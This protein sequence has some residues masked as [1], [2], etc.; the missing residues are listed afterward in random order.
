MTNNTNKNS[1]LVIGSTQQTNRRA[2]RLPAAL[3]ELTLR[4]RADE[5]EAIKVKPWTS[6]LC[7]LIP[8]ADSAPEHSPG[9]MTDS[10]PGEGHDGT[11]PCV[12]IFDCWMW[13][14]AKAN[15]KHERR[16]FRV[17][18]RFP[19]ACFLLPQPD[20]VHTI[21]AARAFSVVSCS[22]TNSGC[23]PVRPALIAI[24]WYEEM[25]R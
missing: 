5:P 1:F 7:S 23:F 4:T 12:R 9:S 3:A 18:F 15:R 22:P 2:A 16:G 19:V 8:K 17:V 24:Y 20:S 14:S 10:I 13:R 25:K 6:R 21:P 11:Y